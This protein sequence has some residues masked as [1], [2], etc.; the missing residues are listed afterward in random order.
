MD[1]YDRA[2]LLAKGV[3]KG[4]VCKGNNKQMYNASL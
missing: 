1:K 2:N 3:A 4:R